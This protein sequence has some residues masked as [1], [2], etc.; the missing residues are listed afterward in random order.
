MERSVSPIHATVGKMHEYRCLC[1]DCEE[2]YHTETLESAQAWFNSHANR[3]HE[4]E[5][6][7]REEEHHHRYPVPDEQEPGN[8]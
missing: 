8:G 4:V 2:E 6:K 5:L 3:Q 1:H 7:R